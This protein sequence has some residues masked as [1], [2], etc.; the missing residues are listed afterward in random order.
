MRCYFPPKLFKSEDICNVDFE[1]VNAPSHIRTIS[2]EL[3][4]CVID[5]IL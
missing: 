3:A 5:E 4:K 1:S 2:E